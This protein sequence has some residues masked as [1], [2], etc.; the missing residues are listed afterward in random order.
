MRG[1]EQADALIEQRERSADAHLA[2]PGRE[3]PGN[4][5]DI[6]SLTAVETGLAAYDGAL[7]VVSHDSAFLDAI[8]VERT[9][10]LGP[11][12]P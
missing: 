12:G 11:A 3:R 7:L 4:H 10:E 1:V 6:E 2:R 9:L 5:L 8:G